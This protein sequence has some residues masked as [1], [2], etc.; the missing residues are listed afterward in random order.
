MNIGLPPDSWPR[1]QATA[2]RRGNHAFD[3]AGRIFK[4]LARAS[5]TDFKPAFTADTDECLLDEQ[6][7][8]MGVKWRMWQIKGF[9]YAA[10]QQEYLDA[11]RHVPGA[12]AAI[13]MAEDQIRIKREEAKRIREEKAA[14]QRREAEERSRLGASVRYT[15]QVV[16]TQPT[17]VQAQP[18]YRDGVRMASDAQIKYLWVLGYKD[19]NKYDRPTIRVAGR[20]IEQLKSGLSLDEVKQTNRMQLKAPAYAYR[21]NACRDNADLDNLWPDLLRDRRDIDQA[22]YQRIIEFARRKRSEINADG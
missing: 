13:R 14:R 18:I 15:A 5:S 8:I 20:L 22:D 1:N 3:L 6:L 17:G 4:P 21:V 11:L 2:P 19:I 10:L 12:A 9:A 16:D 7:V